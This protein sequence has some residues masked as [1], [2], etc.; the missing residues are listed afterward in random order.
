MDGENSKLPS[1]F[2]AMLTQLPNA[3][4]HSETPNFFQWEGIWLLPE[5]IQGA[6]A[7]RSHFEAHDDDV[8]LA[9]TVKSGTTWLK[10]LC[11]CI[12]QN[13][14]SEDEED[15]LIK[16]NPH[17]CVQ[18]LEGQTYAENPEPDLSGMPSP[19]LFHTHLHYRVLPDSIKN[20]KCKIVYITRNPKD[21]FVS[22]WHHCNSTIAKL[23]K[24]GTIPL[25]KEF[26]Y[27]CDGVTLFG[28][29][30][31]HVL[32]YWAQSLKMPNK[33][34]FMKYDELNRDPKGQ[35]KR[36][37]S[38][39]GKAFSSDEEVDKVLWRCSLERLKNLDVN[40]NGV[41][42]GT[43]MPTSVFFRRGVIGDWKNYFTTEMEEKLDN[44]TCKKLEGSGL[45]LDN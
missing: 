38:F 14:R 8:I 36:L 40:K 43:T 7:F 25:E 44:I 32:D 10:A 42:P 33:I 16:H 37:A 17:A 3:S 20:S 27:F 9:S 15:I 21:A 24:S 30:Y 11:S 35:V 29:F 45:D 28:P 41:V 34:L 4:Y 6:L 39:L 26:Q 23:T 22:L 18:T 13:G 1:S 31:D 2:D 19:R 12:M 5:F